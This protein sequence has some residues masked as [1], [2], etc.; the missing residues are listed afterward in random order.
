MAR[1]SCDALADS[2]IAR[3][4]FWNVLQQHVTTT[5]VSILTLQM[6]EGKNKSYSEAER[7]LKSRMKSGVIYEPMDIWIPEWLC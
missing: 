4:R 3:P 6:K 2:A 7:S 5:Q 1:D